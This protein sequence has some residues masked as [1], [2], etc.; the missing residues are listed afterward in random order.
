MNSVRLPIVNMY[1]DLGVLVCSNLDFSAQ[2]GLVVK[3]ASRVSN[4]I[5]RT[6][7]IKKPDFYLHLYRTLVQ[8]LLLYCSTV[9]SP[10]KLKDCVALESIRTRFIKRLALRCK[11]PVDSVML[12]STA[13]LHGEAAV[14]MFERLSTLGV[15]D[16]LLKIEMNGLEEVVLP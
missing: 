5:F 4:L 13:E 1:K 15:E 7:I 8:P 2:V 3:K 9:W 11:V 12:K 16:Y 6:F 10:Y 14:R